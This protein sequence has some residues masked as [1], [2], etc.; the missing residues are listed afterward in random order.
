ML[1][2]NAADPIGGVLGNPVGVT[3]AGERDVAGCEAGPANVGWPA[4]DPAGE[5]PST[6]GSVRAAATAT[7][8]ATVPAAPVAVRRCR[9]AARRTRDCA[10]GHGANDHLGSRSSSRSRS[11]SFTGSSLVDAFGLQ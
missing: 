7:T 2:G 10:S 11:S 1:T 5:L 6:A 8:T 3:G 4:D 9:R